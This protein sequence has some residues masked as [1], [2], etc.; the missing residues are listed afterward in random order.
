MNCDLQ[1]VSF[2]EAEKELLWPISDLDSYK[3]SKY[4]SPKC[5]AIVRS[6]VQTCSH[7]RN[8]S[9]VR[10]AYISESLLRTTKKSNTKLSDPRF[11]GFHMNA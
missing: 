9:F 6:N 3:K 4:R 2:E 7:Q 8:L 1:K 5:K 10:K 11:K